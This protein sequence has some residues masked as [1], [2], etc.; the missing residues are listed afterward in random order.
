MVT[1]SNAIFPLYF[2][3]V[4]K[5]TQLGEG[6]EESEPL[7]PAQ[8]SVTGQI[9]LVNQ[10][11]SGPQ[12]T[13][14]KC[15]ITLPV[16]NVWRILHKDEAYIQF[17]VCV[18]VCA[19]VCTQSLSRVWL[20]ATLWTVAR[21]APLS[22]GFSRQEYWRGLPFP[23]PGDLPD[24]GIKPASLVSLALAGRF[25]TTELPGKPTHTA[26][27]GTNQ[28][29]ESTQTQSRRPV[30]PACQP[31]TYTE[32]QGSERSSGHWTKSHSCNLL[33]TELSYLL[34]CLR[35]HATSPSQGIIFIFTSYGPKAVPLWEIKIILN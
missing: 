22:M 9:P 24:P 16:Q 26:D 8:G 5:Q 28:G 15:L 18:C 30:Y 32:H 6:S 31:V 10:G 14:L 11:I 23:P 20:F 2:S 4:Y 25:F 3:L 19:R 12:W 1:K 29:W 17:C 33:H 7:P 27:P 34:C 35:S 13:L 21:Q